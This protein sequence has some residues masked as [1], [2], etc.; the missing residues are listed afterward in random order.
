MSAGYW[1]IESTLYPDNSNLTTYRKGRMSGSIW[2]TVWW[3]KQEILQS[4]NEKELNSADLYRVEWKNYS[5][6]VRYLRG[7]VTAWI[8]NEFMEKLERITHRQHSR[9]WWWRQ[10]SS[11]VCRLF[12]GW[13]RRGFESGSHQRTAARKRLPLRSKAFPKRRKQWKRWIYEE[14][15][16]SDSGWKENP[17]TR[18][19]YKRGWGVIYGYRV[20]PGMSPMEVLLY[21]RYDDGSDE[22]T[23]RLRSYNWFWFVYWWFVCIPYLANQDCGWSESWCRIWIVRRFL[24]SAPLPWCFPVLFLAFD[25]I[26][27]WLLFLQHWPAVPV[28]LYCTGTHCYHCG[29][30]KTLYGYLAIYPYCRN[31]CKYL[32][33]SHSTRRGNS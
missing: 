8:G 29:N 7:G 9:E 12:W 27:C 20:H 15:G 28:W 18:S 2:R 14:N 10:G 11:A 16:Y 3:E 21:R 4:N 19:I 32:P 30:R 31:H 23:R 6:S 24:L 1:S 13:C 26:N 22:P 17:A 5:S 33:Y 25:T